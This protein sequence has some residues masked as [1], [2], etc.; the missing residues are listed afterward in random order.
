MDCCYL[1]FGLYYDKSNRFRDK[2][3]ILYTQN[4]YLFVNENRQWYMDCCSMFFGLYY[5]KSNQFREQKKFFTL[6]TSVCVQT[7]TD[8][9]MR[10]AAIKLYCSDYHENSRFWR[11]STSWFRI[12]CPFRE[13]SSRFRENLVNCLNVVEL[14]SRLFKCMEC[15]SNLYTLSFAVVIDLRN[16]IIT[17]V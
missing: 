15:A 2:T 13:I 8:N 16:P 9:D 12:R 14:K 1:F 5:D 11:I 10:L 3:K 7:K 6:K 4:E 17:L